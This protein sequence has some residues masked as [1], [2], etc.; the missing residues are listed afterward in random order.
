MADYKVSGENLTAIADAIRTKGGTSAVLSFPDE[1]VS[2]IGDI[3]TGGTA[4]LIE[5]S[6]TANGVYNASTDNADGYSKVTVAV[7]PLPVVTGSFTPEASEKNGV[8]SVAIPYNGSGYPI[9]VGIYPKEGAYKSGTTIANSTQ[10]YA[11]VTY[12]IVKGDMSTSP[13]YT[14]SADNNYAYIATT[15][16]NSDSVADTYSSGYQKNFL[17]YNST[18]PTGTFYTYCVRFS[19]AT[20]MNV[21]IGDTGNVY[22]F[23]AGQEYTYYI[24]YSS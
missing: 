17:M 9:M 16:K 4:T 18:N 7:Y 13:D 22:G 20:T 3:P 8:K 15:F 6:V 5:K 14:A 24:V 19:D 2:A 12:M 10:K 11:T 21:Y 1:F 23:L